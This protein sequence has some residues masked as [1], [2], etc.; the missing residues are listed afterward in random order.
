MKRFTP[1]TS[2]L[3]PHTSHLTPHPT[4]SPSLPHPATLSPTHSLTRSLTRSRNQA[5]FGWLDR[6]QTG[7]ISLSA[8]EETVRLLRPQQGMAAQMTAGGEDAAAAEGEGIVASEALTPPPTTVLLERIRDGSSGQG[9][10]VS[11]DLA[12]FTHTIHTRRM[13]YKADP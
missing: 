4:P 1:H 10:E 6:D 13:T 11:V 7:R 9:A 12:N 3:T 5:T 2:H 8:L